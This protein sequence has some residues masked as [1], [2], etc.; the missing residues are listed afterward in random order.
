[1]VAYFISATDSV[2]VSNRF[3]ALLNDNTPVREC[4]VMFGDGN[5]AGSFAVYHLWLTQANVTRWANLGNLSNEGIDCTMAY[6]NRVIYNAQAHFA[7]S[8]V[9]QYYDTPN[10]TL[11][12]YKWIF[13]DD[14]K[15]LGATDFNKIHNPGNT[16]DDP[17]YQREQLANTF[18]RALGAPW[19]NRRDVVVYV[20]GNRRGPVMEDAQTPGSDYVKEYFPDDSDGYLYKIARWYE[21]G[22]FDSGYSMPNNLASE[23]MILPY[24]TTGGVKKVARYRWTFENR[25]TPDSENNYTKVF[26]LIDAAST[27][28]TPNY[29]SNMESQVNMENWMRVFA[30]NH[31]A[32]NWDSFGCSSGQNLYPYVGALGAKWTLL[33]FDFNIGLGI[34]GSYPPGQDLFVTLGGDSNMTG[35]YSEPAFLRMYWRALQELVSN[36]PLNLAQSVPLIEAKYAALTANGMTVEDPALNLIPWLTQ[37][38]PQV[39][40]QVN[41]ANAGSFSVNPNV[42]VT[43]DLATLT[44]QA[45][46]NVSSIWINGVAYSPTW[47]TVINW[48]LT[49]PLLHGTNVV[50]LTGVDRYGEPIAGDT[51]T[52]SVVYAGTN[53]PSPACIDYPQ[54]GLVYTQNFDGLP[55]PG[56]TSVNDSNPVTLDG[57]IY[58]LGTPF[59]FAQPAVAT[60]GTGGLGVSSMAGWHGYGVLTSKFGATDGDQTTGGAVSFGSPNSSDRALGLLATSSTGGTAFGVKFRNSAGR[61]LN[62]LSLSC[63]GEIW[64]QSDLSKTLQCYYFIDP[65]GTNPFPTNAT[66]FVPALNVNF[67]TV[68]AASGGMA[69]NGTLS[70]NQTNLSVLNQVI[71]NWPPGAMLWLVWQM[72]DSTGKAQGL[73]LDN[74]S[75]SASV[76]LPL[77]LTIPAGGG[78]VLINWPSVQGQMYQLEYCTNL[79]NSTW[80]PSG[81]PVTGTGG[82]MTLTNNLSAAQQSFFRLQLVN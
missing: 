25:R 64:R 59:E 50:N 23:C 19:L 55:D 40:A 20:N 69:T 5:P 44:G 7:G 9:H 75:F 77:S 2:G 10:G 14:D 73:A 34:D 11:C 30:A 3:P 65:S 35:I 17:T 43:N 28:G 74:L 39:A 18:L 38:S 24:D 47:S 82:T 45:P 22:A 63:T 8:P 71:T 16:G 51:G 48:T 76:A 4:L 56:T 37:A 21:F 15:F 1:M 79:V 6:A 72:T 61:T 67:P 52:V 36:G 70:V 29:V 54:A 31:A 33:M 26:S 49:A 66:A 60:G 12:S 81:S 53:A 13:P 42:S 80:T 58:S 27:H 78:K 62:E 32:G 57:V 41:A 46:F 68:A